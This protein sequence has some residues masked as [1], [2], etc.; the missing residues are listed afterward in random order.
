QQQ[1]VA[2]ARALIQDVD[3]ILADEPTGNLDSKTAAEIMT[4]FDELSAQGKTI[5]IITHGAEVARAA[6]RTLRVRDG[7]LETAAGPTA[8]RADVVTSGARAIAAPRLGARLPR[9]ALRSLPGAFANLTRNRAKS[10]LTM[11]GVIIG[12]AAVLAMISLGQF[13][14]ARIM[15]GF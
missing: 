12:I 1:R 15:E 14:K 5:V 7:R 10:L 8:A 13:S 11:L 2:I 3:L 6:R 4:I 9:L